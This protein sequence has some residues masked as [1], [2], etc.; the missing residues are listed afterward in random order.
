MTV[1]ASLK[2]LLTQKIQL[3]TWWKVQSDMMLIIIEKF[4]IDVE[5]TKTLCYNE[6]VNSG[7]IVWL[8]S[9]K[10]VNFETTHL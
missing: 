7:I 4:L 5:K 1:Y 3:W 9:E 6:N 2:S 8:F 10:E